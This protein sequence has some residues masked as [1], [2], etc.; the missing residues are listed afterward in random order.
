MFEWGVT[1]VQRGQERI[2]LRQVRGAFVAWFIVS[3]ERSWNG[4]LMLA[5]VAVAVQHLVQLLA[6]F[7]QACG[8]AGL[9][10]RHV[11]GVFSQKLRTQTFG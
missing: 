1:A 7:L 6:N 11:G 10:Q 3:H 8:L 9:G 4:G 2:G 5:E